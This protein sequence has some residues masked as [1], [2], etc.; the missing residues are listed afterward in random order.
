MLV[1]CL[2]SRHQYQLIHSCRVRS[3]HTKTVL[4]SLLVGLLA[5][6]FF[7]RRTTS[8]V[9]GGTELFLRACEA[10]PFRTL[11]PRLPLPLTEVTV[12]V[13]VVVVVVVVVLYASEVILL[14]LRRGC[15]G[16]VSE[17]GRCL[18]RGLRAD[19]RLRVPSCPSGRDMADCGCGMIFRDVMLCGA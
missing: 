13:S 10:C 9:S 17:S 18:L 19:V 8:S 5:A 12:V 15:C 1:L 14:L 6:P 4:P 11:F 16:G 7:V 3:C 2:S